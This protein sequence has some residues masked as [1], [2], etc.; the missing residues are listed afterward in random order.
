MILGFTE[1]VKLIE[2]TTL[3][4]YEIVLYH[5]TLFAAHWLVLIS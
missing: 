1:S 2:D 3:V 4:F 5:C